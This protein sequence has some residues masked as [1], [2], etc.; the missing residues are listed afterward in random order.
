MPKAPAAIKPM[1]RKYTLLRNKI[2]NRTTES[3]RLGPRIYLRKKI[4]L[5]F[6]KTASIPT[7]R[8]SNACI[9]VRK[10]NKSNRLTANGSLT[11]DS[12]IQPLRPKTSNTRKKPSEKT[13]LT[14][15]RIEPN[16]L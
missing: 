4:E 7:K 9:G 14:I 16:T 15:I 13:V 6:E 1:D 11:N 2:S 12:A 10:I 5:G 3:L 8:L